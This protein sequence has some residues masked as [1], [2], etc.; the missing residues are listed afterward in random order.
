MTPAR[1][2]QIGALYHAAQAQPPQARAAFLLEACADDDELRR[3]VES[4]LAADAAAGDFIDEP[5]LAAAAELLAAT[6]SP[7]LVATDATLRR[8]PPQ[9]NLPTASAITQLDT[10]PGWFVQMRRQPRFRWFVLCYGVFV[11]GCYFLSVGLVVRYG[12]LVKDF[13]WEYAARG[14][15]WYVSAVDPQGVA[16]GRLQAGDEILAINEDRWII[17]LGEDL[18]LHLNRDLLAPDRPYSLRV[19]RRTVTTKVELPLPLRRDWRVRA[20]LVVALL[21]SVPFWLLALLVGW[22]KPAQ[23]LTQLACLASFSAAYDL[24]ATAF[25]P[26]AAFLPE[27]VHAFQEM[28]SLDVLSFAVTYHFFSLFP[29]GAPPQ[30]GWLW[31]RRVLYVWGA[32]QFIPRVFMR[33]WVAAGEHVF[34]QQFAAHAAAY[35]AYIRFDGALYAALAVCMM[36]GAL[37]VVAHHYRRIQEADQRRRLKWLLYGLGFGLLPSTLFFAAFVTA[38]SLGTYTPSNSNFLLLLQLSNI[39][40]VCIPLAFGYANLKHRV[41]EIQVVVRRGVQYL[42]AKNVL[43]G[44]LFLPLAVLVL[45]QAVSDGC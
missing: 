28:F 2:Q 21:T 29:A 17:R 43:R 31:L 9:A 37:A 6:A 26:V 41:F 5:A 4:L 3:E 19:A 27:P 44:L 45:H 25:F 7:A 30:R 13:G 15:R 32:L 24:A 8:T 39:S 20:R 16:A 38:S 11:L 33:H 22:L 36:C 40:L 1:Y 34:R 35:A 12:D 18:N 14:E 23:R 42:L 10:A